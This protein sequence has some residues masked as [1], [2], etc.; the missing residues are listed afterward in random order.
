LL[1]TRELGLTWKRAKV[2][3]EGRDTARRLAQQ[4]PEHVRGMIELVA[5]DIQ[6]RSD[7]GTLISLNYLLYQ[8]ALEIRAEILKDL[9]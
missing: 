7:Q 5:T 4:L 9:K 3:P 1:L 8:P 2:S 6:D